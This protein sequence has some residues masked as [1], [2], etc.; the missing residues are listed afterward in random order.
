MERTLP[1]HGLNGIDDGQEPIEAHEDQGVD[2]DEGSRDD[3]KLPN[4][5]PRKKM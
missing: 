5:A 4:F 3:Q 1:S 2:A